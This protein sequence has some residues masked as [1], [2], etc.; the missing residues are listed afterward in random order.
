MDNSESFI[1]ISDFHSYSWPVDIIE[2]KFINTY[3][4]IY[5]LGDATDRG[6]DNKGTNGINLLIRIMELTKKY[7]D[8]VIYIPGNHDQMLYRY[9]LDG[10]DKYDI[11]RN[12]GRNTILKIKEIKKYNQ[13]LF[14][15][16]F[17]WLGNLPIQRIHE[18][19]GQKYA[20]AHALF[21][22]RIY[23]ENPSFNLKDLYDMSYTHR[24]KIKNIMWFRKDD[25][26]YGRSELPDKDT[27][28]VVG[29]T[30]YQ[31][32]KNKSLNLINN[33]FEE[34]RVHSVDGGI[35]IG[36]NL[37]HYYDGGDSIKII[38]PKD[39]EYMKVIKSKKG[40]PIKTL[41]NLKEKYP[42]IP[43]S[44][45]IFFDKLIN[46][47]KSEKELARL[48]ILIIVTIILMGVAHTL[49]APKPQEE[50]PYYQEETI[51]KK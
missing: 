14:D 10:L 15:E 21:N 40:R 3:D 47:T 12:G 33:Q 50:M 46:G 45:I 25:G 18:Y 28:M 29:H 35:G 38:D 2:E 5:I 7:P 41:K 44:I 32:R 1:V 31:L 24:Q 51:H 48:I 6:V 30:P 20:L 19:N 36:S 49:E 43:N 8:K 23:D 11:F 16:L 39:N 26:L 4:K 9:M 34:I 17:N 13:P 27:I 42:F 22:Q 37:L